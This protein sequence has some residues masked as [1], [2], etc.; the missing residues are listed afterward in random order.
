MQKEQASTIPTGVTA[1]SIAL[2]E[3]TFTVL[4][5]MYHLEEDCIDADEVFEQGWLKEAMSVRF[6]QDVIKSIL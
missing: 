3:Y 4:E 2:K 5:D 6:R 1:E